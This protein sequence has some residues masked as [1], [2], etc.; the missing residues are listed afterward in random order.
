VRKKLVWSLLFQR[1][2]F[3]SALVRSLSGGMQVR[4]AILPGNVGFSML[5]FGGFSFF[6]S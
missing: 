3:Q 2:K 4:F 5:C 6:S 1:E